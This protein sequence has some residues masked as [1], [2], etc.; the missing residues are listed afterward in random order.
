M[1]AA[2]D[3]RRKRRILVCYDG[4][5]ESERALARAAEIASA[6][7]SDVT[8]VSVAEPTSPTGPFTAEADPI[9]A[10]SHNRLLEKAL[11]TLSDQGIGAA[12]AE[13]TGAPAESIVAV[14]RTIGA[15]LIVV[16]SRHSGALQR[17]FVGSVSREL[18]AEA[19]CDVLV[20]R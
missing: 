1:T 9:E 15:D 13:P 4:S 7:P 6:V 18:V 11:W 19:P 12:T 2:S 5:P 17:L 3:G 14:A 16:G 10:Q 20:V 8:V